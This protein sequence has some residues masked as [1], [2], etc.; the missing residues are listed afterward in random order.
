MS[1]TQQQGA[2]DAAKAADLLVTVAA[3]LNER[4]AL[5]AGELARSQAM[6]REASGELIKAFRGAAARST[7]RGWRATTPRASIARSSLREPIRSRRRTRSMWED[8]ASRS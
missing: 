7:S 4:L 3:S 2:R 5:T 6:L 8:G 1:E